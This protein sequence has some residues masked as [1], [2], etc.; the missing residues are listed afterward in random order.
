MLFIADGD[1]FVSAEK[2]ALVLSV[3]G[4]TNTLGKCTKHIKQRYTPILLHLLP[5]P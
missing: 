3:I 1:D 5:V 4:I 2:A